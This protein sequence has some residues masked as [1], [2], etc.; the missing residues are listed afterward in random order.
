[1]SKNS[2]MESKRVRAAL[3]EEQKMINKGKDR[4]LRKH[5]HLDTVSDNI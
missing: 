1:M 5:L 4:R 3:E 2:F